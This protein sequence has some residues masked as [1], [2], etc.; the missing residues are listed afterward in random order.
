MCPA[1]PLLR[2][3][4]KPTAGSRA[5]SRG[6]A[7]SSSLCQE[8]VPP[9]RRADGVFAHSYPPPRGP[10][11]PR[12]PSN[13]T[14]AERAGAP[15]GASR[16]STRLPP[17]PPAS[18][19][20]LQRPSVRGRPTTRAAGEWKICP[21]THEAG[22]RDPE[23]WGSAARTFPPCPRRR[24]RRASAPRPDFASRDDAASSCRARDVSASAAVSSGR[25]PQSPTPPHRA[26]PR[27][28]RVSGAAVTVVTVSRGLTSSHRAVAARFPS[29]FP[30][31]QTHSSG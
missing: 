31:P 5:R 19:P 1:P 18:C 22:T 14:S 17:L 13:L 6:R 12:L 4:P 9:A 29:V 26:R 16:P 25:R 20:P 30:S 2:C 10:S 21:T 3:P 24:P 8:P 7:E 27:I 15:P 11:T 28:A 23:A